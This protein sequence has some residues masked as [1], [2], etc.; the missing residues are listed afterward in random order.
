MG[1]V[2]S[3]RMKE[4]EAHRLEGFL[5]PCTF[6]PTQ[7]QS[8]KPDRLSHDT[9]L[10]AGLNFQ[11]TKVVPRIKTYPSLHIGQIGLFIWLFSKRL[12]FFQSL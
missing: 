1:P 10:R 3:V 7:E 12:L 9:G 11:P 2:K 4:M 5:I 6:E 8:G